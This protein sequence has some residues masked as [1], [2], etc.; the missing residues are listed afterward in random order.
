[1]KKKCDM[2]YAPIV[3]FGFNR[4]DALRNTIASL[5]RN[6]E[7]KDS[8]LFVFVDGPREGKM[9]EK[10][11]VKDV[12]EYVK[13]ITGFKSLHYTFAENN[14]GLADSIIGGVSEVINQY[15]RVIVLEDDLVLMP[16]FLNFLNQGLEIYENTQ[17]VMS[18][19]GHS[20]KVKVPAD[21]PYDAYFFTRSSSWGW[22]TWKDRWDLVDWKLNDWDSVVANRK[23]FIKSQGSDVFKMLRDCKL[24]KN[25]SWAIRFCYAQFVQN[26]LSVIPNK[27][28]VDNE[29]FGGDGTNCKRYSRFKFQLN[30]CKEHLDF[31]MP[32][33]VKLDSSLYKQALWY[34]SIPLRIWSRIMYI[35]KK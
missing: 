16:N 6:E 34:H 33:E 9:G 3:V 30:D 31:R 11:K 18:V 29:G 10:K 22:A 14:K 20:C 15:G 28:L 7:A 4:L 1:M 8:D 35:L 32:S 21:Y 13:S 5:L 26:R 25:H 24:G 12:R 27:S 19:C 23:A 17:K 2:N